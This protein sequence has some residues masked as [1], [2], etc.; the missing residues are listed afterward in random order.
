MFKTKATYFLEA[1]ICHRIW[2]LSCWSLQ[3]IPKPC[4]VDHQAREPH[5]ISLFP[6]LITN[7]KAYRKVT[8][9]PQPHISIYILDPPGSSGQAV[10]HWANVLPWKGGLQPLK[11]SFNRFS[12]AIDRNRLG[13]LQNETL[14]VC[15]EESFNRLPSAFKRWP[16]NLDFARTFRCFKADSVFP[17]SPSI[18]GMENLQDTRHSTWCLERSDKVFWQE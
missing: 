17:L 7:Y 11:P 6:T 12:L 8:Y 14:L 4:S 16:G 3:P 15:A 10:C 1:P 18:Y 5:A 13:T 2:S 9:Q